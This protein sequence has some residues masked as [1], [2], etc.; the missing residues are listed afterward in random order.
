METRTQFGPNDVLVDQTMIC[1]ASRLLEGYPEGDDYIH[2][3]FERDLLEPGH[4]SF[5][6]GSRLRPSNIERLVN[7]SM[8]L[9]AMALHE[10]LYV[11]QGETP[12]DEQ[13]LQ[14]PKYLVGAGIVKQLDPAKYMGDVSDEARILLAQV[15]P[16][17]ELQFGK[18][19]TIGRIVESIARFLG[20]CEHPREATSLTD[21]LSLCLAQ[22]Y[23]GDLALRTWERRAE[24]LLTR[25]FLV[26]G[27]QLLD[28]A[29]RIGTG[30]VCGAVSHVRTLVYWRLAE[31]AR[32]VL[33]PSCRRAPQIDLF[34]D[35]LRAS[36]AER[37]YGVVAEAFKTTVEAVFADEAQIPLYLPPT[38]AIFLE[39]FASTGCLFEAIDS[40]RR[41][42]AAIRRSF[43]A[44]EKEFISASSLGERLRVKHRVLE[45]L[46]S[47][48]LHY[49]TRD[50]SKLETVM[51]FAPDI[52][53][54]LSNPSDPTKYSKELLTVP[55]SW[56][57]DWWRKRPFRHVFRLRNR[58]ES[59]SNY[60]NLASQVL[61]VSFDKEQK[62][63]FLA[64]YQQY[65]ARYGRE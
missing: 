45:L 37:A 8:L 40:F 64:L 36:V 30:S 25:P 17:L 44:L 26:L 9:D 12:P 16:A 1:E 43:L 34:S 47:L 3:L 15:E 53:N 21:A 22:G 41:E 29:G 58:L 18:E 24:D 23:E 5:I 6:L 4:Y 54:P 38:L 13:H 59:V 7:L 56:V 61:A 31:H 52:L 42:F 20:T 33:Y 63:S 50:D 60:E 35:H 57:R 27:R 14:L 19:R 65:L 28:Y 49:T 51:G 55:L 11:L 32:I 2:W 39:L 48:E 62:E 10:C 46:K